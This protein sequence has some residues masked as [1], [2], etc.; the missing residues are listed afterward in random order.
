MNAPMTNLALATDPISPLTSRRVGAERQE[1]ADL[2]AAAV[3]GDSGA[4][5]ELYS[6]Y[7]GLLMAMAMRILGHPEDA[8]E[9]LQDALLYAW[10][11]ADSYNPEKAS[12]STWLVLITRSRCLDRLRLRKTYRE[13]CDGLTRESQDVGLEPQGFDHA[14]NEERGRRIRAALLQLPPDQRRVLELRYY[15]GLTQ[16]EVAKETG[17]PLGTVKTRTLLALKK[18]RS[19]L[20]GQADTLL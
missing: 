5:A 11:R 2:L 8:E 14:L 17:A 16:A 4:F 9:A 13:A 1:G 6:R 7:S 10:K 19:G 12:V 3:R 20:N 15:Q 18:L